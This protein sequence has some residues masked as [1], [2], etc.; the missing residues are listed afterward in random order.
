MRNRFELLLGIADAAGNDRAAKRKRAGFQNEAARREMV[1]KR[2]MYDVVAAGF[3]FRPPNGGFC[4]WS[5]VMS[6][7]RST[8]SFAS[9]S[10]EVM[11]RGSTPLRCAAQPGAFIA[12]AICFGNS[13]KCLRSRSA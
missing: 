8:G 12:R 7:L 6:D 10:R 1:G 11:A 13:K 2:V 4:F 9:A 5:S 3:A